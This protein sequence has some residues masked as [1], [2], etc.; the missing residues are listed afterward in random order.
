MSNMQ[1]AELL[2]TKV[3]DHACDDADFTLVL[4][5]PLY[6][7][8]LRTKLARPALEL[9]T[10]RA[11]S[12]V[13]ICWIPLLILTLFD[14][15]ALGGVKL[16]FLLD[17]GVYARFLAALPLM[18][19]AE[20]IV[21]HR[22]NSI[23]QQ[24]VDRG[25]VRTEDRP[26]FNEL[27][28]SAKR[29]Q[30]SSIAEAILFVAAITVGH[31]AW[32]Q[33]VLSVVPTWF[34][35]G[36]GPDQRLTRAGYW[37]AFVSLP[38]LRFILLRWYFRVFVWYRF[39]WGVRTLPLHFNLFHPDRA[40]GLG[41]LA[42]SVSAFAPVLVA[43]T[44]LLSGI[45]GDRILHAGATLP[46]FKMEIVGVVAFLMLLVLTPLTFFLF[47]LEE[48]GRKAKR[49]YG[50]LASRYVEDFHYKW[51]RG[52]RPEGEPL[53]GTSD[54]QSLADLGNAYN[55][56]SDIR[57]VPI[58]K[59]VVLRL[60]VILIVPILPLTLTMVPLDKIVDRIIK[61]VF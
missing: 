58:S 25:I 37:Y 21:Y 61:L 32:K 28:A 27:I 45:I 44:I 18:I 26:R 52:Q 13:L 16:P 11:A 20:W 7:L 9:V 50:L 4:G 43:Q 8:Y 42:G 59:R 23:V 53:L 39:L 36:I 24:F 38:I 48:A 30:S 31:W 46:T 12:I 49:E 17:L 41:F 35:S 47:R 10:R 1:Q 22:L 2:N 40:G 5:G 29:L 33:N 15:Y 14:G 19:A 3:T 34:A 60:A 55:V 51:I 56:V 6:Q 54:I 57:L